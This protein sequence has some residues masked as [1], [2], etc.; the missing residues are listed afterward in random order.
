LATRY[1]CGHFFYG[2]FVDRIPL[3]AS[4]GPIARMG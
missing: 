2:H 4:L 3:T 1:F